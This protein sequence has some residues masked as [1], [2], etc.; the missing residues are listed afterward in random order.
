M[1]SMPAGRVAATANRCPHGEFA[2]DSHPTISGGH[3][4]SGAGFHHVVFRKLEVSV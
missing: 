2:D 4:T 3:L 1:A